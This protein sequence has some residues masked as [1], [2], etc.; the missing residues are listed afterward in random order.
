MDRNL[1][2]ELVRVTEAA[3][4][5]CARWVGRG[6]AH[7]AD[8]AAVDA[9]RQALNSLNIEGIVV[10]GEGERDEAPMLYIGEKVGLG[11][12]PPLDIA[13]DPLECTASV[14]LGRPNAM[15]VIAM[16]DRGCFLH[17]PDI[18]M[19]KIAVGSSARGAID[20]T[21]PPKENLKNIAKA[22]KVGVEDLTV[23]I[24]DRPRHEDLIREVRSAGARIHLISDGDVSAAIAAAIEGT[25]IDVLM[26]IGGAPEGVLTAAALRCIGGDF[27]GRLVP[28]NP[29]EIERA[30]KM[31]ITDLN[32]IW[33][34]DELARTDNIMFAVTGVTDGDLLKGVRFRGV[35]VETHSIVM[36]ARTGTIRFI[37][38][39]H[40]L[41]LAEKYPQR[42]F[43]D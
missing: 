38:T 29:T 41:G 34:M 1:A 15:A 17:V 24:L 8:Q 11:G 37:E 14:A 40:H 5:S 21:A 12:S 10:I 25:G 3:A 19:E 6:D 39:K 43:H 2:L 9:M 26:G 4:I 20:I 36:R 18:Y 22:K 32:K 27:Q 30:Q 13:L 42:E 16:A 23:V 33:Q 28:R 31:G 35:A 7:A